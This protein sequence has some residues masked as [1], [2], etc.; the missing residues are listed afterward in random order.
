MGGILSDDERDIPQC[1]PEA[2]IVPCNM[3]DFSGVTTARDF[4]LKVEKLYH[5]YLKKHCNQVNH[6][7]EYVS[8]YF[9]RNGKFIS[10]RFL[11]VCDTHC[12][13][14]M[15]LSQITKATLPLHHHQSTSLMRIKIRTRNQ[16]QLSTPTQLRNQPQQQNTPLRK[17][18]R[19]RKRTKT[20][21]LLHLLHFE[22]INMFQNGDPI[23]AK[24]SEII[25]ELIM[26]TSSLKLA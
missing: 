19:I 2:G 25:A 16:H 24:S 5:D 23:N 11:S 14:T 3:V 15:V 10:M 12:S 7:N 17:T 1:E 4:H 8:L 9:N 13:V 20:K 22:Q 6:K 21:K 18:R 26:G